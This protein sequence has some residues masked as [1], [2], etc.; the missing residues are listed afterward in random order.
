MES[1]ENLHVVDPYPDQSASKLISWLQ[2]PIDFSNTADPTLIVF[3]QKVKEGKR[4][5]AGRLFLA[6][7]L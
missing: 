7:S 6:S 4:I 2:I 3:A 5:D 1:F